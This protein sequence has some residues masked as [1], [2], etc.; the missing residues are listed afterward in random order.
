MVEKILKQ[1]NMI[2]TLSCQVDGLATVLLGKKNVEETEPC[3]EEDC[4]FD[5]INNNGFK[6]ERI[7]KDLDILIRQIKGEN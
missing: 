1:K 6:L 2:D 7:M 4:L 5:T 3:M